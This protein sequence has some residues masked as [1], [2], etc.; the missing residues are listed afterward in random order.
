[1]TVLNSDTLKRVCS[2][3]MD[4]FKALFPDSV[5]AIPVIEDSHKKGKAV[6]SELDAGDSYIY[7]DRG[8]SILGVAH[9]DYVTVPFHYCEADLNGFV[10]FCPR[11]D[12]RLGVWGLLDVLPSLVECDFDVLLTTGEESGSSSASI[13][14]PSHDYNWI[15]ELDRRGKDCVTYGIDSKDWRG[16][17]GRSGWSIGR[18]SFSDICHLDNLG[19]CAVNFG[20]GYH[21]EHTRLCYASIDDIIMQL[22]RVSRFINKNWDS[23]FEYVP[24]IKS[25]KHK[26]LYSNDRGYSSRFGLDYD[27]LHCSLCGTWLLDFELKTGMCVSCAE[28]LA[29]DSVGADSVDADSVGMD[30]SECEFCGL[31]FSIDDLVSY[32]GALICPDC[33]GW[34]NASV[35]DSA[36][37][38]D[39]AD[40]I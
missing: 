36:V 5:W 6:K 20:V 39:S 38:G 24:L 23:V 12:D 35:P 26:P 33:L 3:S 17:L 25:S 22:K 2:F 30:S 31:S 11:L 8:A 27:D 15:F 21:E 28:S 19:V 18:G 32:D 34:F 13:F 7:I 16:A 10:V 9:L 40:S 4:D 14:K 37:G 1:M 29:S